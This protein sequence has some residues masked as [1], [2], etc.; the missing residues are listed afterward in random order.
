[1]RAKYP[2]R[3]PVIVGR[4]PRSDLP[5]IDKQKFLVPM[6]LTFGQF[7]YVIRKRIKLKPEC[8]IFALVN[9]TLPPTCQMISDIDRHQRSADGFIYVS[10][11]GENVFGRRVEC[12][13]QEASPLTQSQQVC[14]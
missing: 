1:M 7:V 6:D 3:V 5:P 14:K 4:D 12:W 10:Y 11:T 13:R 8:A 9:N 2:G